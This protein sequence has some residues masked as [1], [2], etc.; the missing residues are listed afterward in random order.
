MKIRDQLEALSDISGYKRVNTSQKGPSYEY[1]PSTQPTTKD[2]F[3]SLI[4]K[5][6]ELKKQY[7]AAQTSD[8]E[9]WGPVLALHPDSPIAEYANFKN[10]TKDKNVRSMFQEMNHIHELYE[11]N[12]HSYCSSRSIFEKIVSKMKALVSTFESSEANDVPA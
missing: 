8:Y 7:E 1:W 2:H 4:K 11:E 12:L 10:S 9:T 6:Q 3:L 5:A